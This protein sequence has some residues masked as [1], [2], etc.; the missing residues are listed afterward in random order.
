MVGKSSAGVKV[1]ADKSN[2]REVDSK[3]VSK[4]LGHGNGPEK[5]RE[6]EFNILKEGGK[7]GTT[8]EEQMAVKGRRRIM[9]QEKGQQLKADAT[10]VA[11]E[12]K[13][14]D[15]SDFKQ[16]NSDAGGDGKSERSDANSRHFGVAKKDSTLSKA[17]ESFKS[18]LGRA[19]SGQSS[20]GSPAEMKPLFEGWSAKITMQN[21]QRL[22]KSGES[23]AFVRLNPQS[24]G[25]VEVDIK[26]RSGEISVTFRAENPAAIAEL[27][28]NIGD[29][30]AS[31]KE[32][33]LKLGDYD[34][35]QGFGEG[36][37]GAA[38]DGRA[39]DEG[40]GHG[41]RSGQSFEDN[42]DVNKAKRRKILSKK[43][44]SRAVDV[45]A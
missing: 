24:L 26:N 33:G 41:R 8:A 40:G 14:S 28:N 27:Q 7:V 2:F 31:L 20:S 18:Q 29:L 6:D 23:R 39:Q 9:P 4:D 3:G 44:N 45:V 35:R 42:D 30:R 32:A 11:E 21:V 5:Q 1:G 37:A 25:M 13:A 17:S 34:F 36:H 12:K 19:Q 10:V 38:D 15:N 43:R 22:I 16:G